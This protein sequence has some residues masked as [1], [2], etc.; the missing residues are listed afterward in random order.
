MDDL[1]VLQDNPLHMAQATF[2]NNDDEEHVITQ[3]LTYS[4]TR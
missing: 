2:I 3:T 4:K 1:Q